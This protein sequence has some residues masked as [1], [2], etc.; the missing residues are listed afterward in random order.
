MRVL[1]DSSVWIDYFKSGVNSE[2]LDDLIDEN[3]V[4]TNE[5]ILTELIPFLKLKNQTS[6]IKALKEV[7]KFPLLINWAELQKYQLDCLKAG[8]NGIGIPDLMIAQNGIQNDCY[9]FSLD[10][11]FNLM[12]SVLSFKTY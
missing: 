2:R 12:K 8:V 6:L 4:Y 10:K 1:V 5:I 3:L 7:A 9:I 11:H